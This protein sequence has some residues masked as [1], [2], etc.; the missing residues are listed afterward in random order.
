MITL[1]QNDIDSLSLV[2]WKEAR[3]EGNEGM[4][5]VMHVIINRVG[6]PGFAHTLHDVIYGKNQFTSMSVP[7]DPEFNL[8]P[9]SDDPQYVF[10]VSLAP[11]IQGETDPTNGAHYYAD[12]KYTTSG[13]FFRNIVQN[14]TDH[15]QVAVIGRHTF[16]L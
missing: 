11:G 14:S 15:P 12:L 2:A 3:G 1:D 6:H 7:T 8:Q 5:A 9:A 16:W 10:C 4:D 13:W